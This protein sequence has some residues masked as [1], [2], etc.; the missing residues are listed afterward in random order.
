M[1]F[2]RAATQAIWIS[3]YFNEVGL[4]IAKPII[5][6][7]DNSGVISNSI[8]HKNHRRTKHIDIRHH[9]VKECTKSEEITFK[10]VP[11]A[12]NLADI[13][14]KSLP[15]EATRKFAMSLSLTRYDMN[16]P[17]QGEC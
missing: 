3:K 2:S 10:Y 17:V 1:A 14:T 7:A 15:H 5:I 11:S 13:L 12:E 16:V 9:F 6:H 4:P 8:N